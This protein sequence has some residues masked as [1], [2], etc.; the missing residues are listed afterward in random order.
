METLQSLW[1]NFGDMLKSALPLS[2]F[3]PYIS[4]FSSLPYIGWINWFLPV[5]GYLIVRGSWIGAIG[6]Y[7]LYMA[8]LRYVKAIE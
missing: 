2:P 5:K 7:Y 1:N 3:Q 4:Y 6:T 8:I